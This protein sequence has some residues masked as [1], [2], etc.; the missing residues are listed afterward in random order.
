MD[1]RESNEPAH[2]PNDLNAEGVVCVCPNCGGTNIWLKPG[3]VLHDALC[4]DCRHADLLENFPPPS[5]K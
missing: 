4:L 5:Q 2:D 1:I 3:W